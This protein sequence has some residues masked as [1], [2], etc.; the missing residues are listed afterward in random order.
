MAGIATY[1][2]EKAPECKI[3][4]VE[5]SGAASLTAASNEGHQVTLTHVDTFVDGASVKRI[6]D[7]PWATY[8]ALSEGIDV[9]TVDEG[10][11]CT[12]ML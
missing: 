2:S 1:L 8:Q 3:V 11:V 9:R 12:E 7:T 4:A 10:A 6:G 5:P